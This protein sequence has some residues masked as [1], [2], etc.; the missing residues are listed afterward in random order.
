MILI[1]CY[2]LQGSISHAHKPGTTGM[3]LLNFSDVNGNPMD[4]WYCL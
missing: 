4:G 1:F 3:C 2:N